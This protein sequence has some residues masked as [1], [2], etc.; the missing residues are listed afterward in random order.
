MQVAVTTDVGTGQ[1]QN[2]DGWCAEQLH[3]NVTLLAVADGF[4]RPSGVGASSLVIDAMR[5]IVRRELRRATFPARSLSG[6]DIR[7]LLRLSFAH[8]NE[9]LLSLSGG[10]AD[11]VPAACTCTAILIVSNQ[12]FIG[13]LGDC[14]AYLLRREELV[15]LTSD[16]SLPFDLVRSGRSQRGPRRAQVRPLLTRALGVELGQAAS[17]KITH[18]TLHPGDALLLCSDGAYRGVALGD[19]QATV[20][21]K[22]RVEWI[23]DRIVALARSAGGSDDA[24]VIFARDATEHGAAAA[25]G[26]EQRQAKR[27]LAALAAGFVL[28]SAALLSTVGF[29]QAES[30]LYLGADSAG[31][32]TLYAGSPG[33]LLGMPLHVARQSYGLSQRWLAPATRRDLGDGISVSSADSAASIVKKW[34]AHTRP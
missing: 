10:G 26:A 21:A 18:Y 8:A 24:S 13:H 6:N 12:A 31:V 33:S 25:G 19:L 30:H 14:R 11:H 32:V 27:S 23:A 15:Q 7:D 5:E 1:R 29:R 17:P 34:R 4:G 16:E 9:R 28:F 22:Q 3:K 2:D 20:I